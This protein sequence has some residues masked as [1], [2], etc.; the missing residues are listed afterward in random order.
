MD[1]SWE[2]RRHAAE[3]EEMARGTRDAES[4]GTWSRMAERWRRCA[5][6]ADG[7][8]S[9]AEAAAARASRHRRSKFTKQAA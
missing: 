5:E 4:R 9:A 6:L 7:E 2:F 8:R 1:P 3:C